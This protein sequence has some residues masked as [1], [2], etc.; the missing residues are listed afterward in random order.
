VRV[1]RAVL[2][3]APAVA[4]VH[5]RTWQGAYPGLIPQSYLDALRPEDRLPMWEE[6]LARTAWPR[7]GTFVL[8]GPGGADVDL[9]TADGAVVG[10][11]SFGPSR[12]GDAADSVGEL[13]TLY[14]DPGSWERGGATRL[15]DAVVDALRDAGFT[16]ATLWVL[17]T[18]A[19]ARRFYERRGWRP[20][21][22]T[23]LHDWGAFVA[24]DV[25]YGRALD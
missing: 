17:D 2:D 18:N 7:L 19:R 20:D 12:D 15:I 8:L 1:R 6:V 13:H 23:Q 21:G 14:V 25:R 16:R 5:V 24:T 3:D 22:S 4:A 11:A 9:R 10:F